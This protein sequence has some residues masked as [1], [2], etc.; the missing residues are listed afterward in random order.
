VNIRVARRIVGRTPLLAAISRVEYLRKGYSG[1]RKYTLW[2]KGKPRYLLRLSGIELR[3]RR[4]GEFDALGRLRRRGVLCPEAHLFGVA[5]EARVCYMVLDY[6]PGQCA[7]QEL[8]RLSEKRQFGIGVAAGRQLRLMHQLRCPDKSFDWHAHRKAKYL[9]HVKEARA[10]GLTFAGQGE[11]ERYVK[12]NFGV[13]RGRPVRFQHDDYHPGN[14]IVR[15]GRLAGVIDFNRCDWGDPLHDFYKVPM[16]CAPVSTPFAMGQLRGY[17]P[18][19]I[20]KSFWREYNLYVAMSLHGCLLWSHLHDPRGWNRWQSWV[21][22]VLD[23]HDFVGSGPP[24]WFA[25]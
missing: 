18:A 17:F 11:V 15:N 7:W 10:H 24:A 12:R 8:P 4:Q 25:R 20:P 2:E 19:G 5:E 13:M 22:H 1:D 9:R 23:S 21:R 6:I 3:R 16:F 14:L